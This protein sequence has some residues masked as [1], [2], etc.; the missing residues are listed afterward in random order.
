MSFEEQAARGVR[1][2][3]TAVVKGLDKRDSYFEL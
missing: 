1:G 3:M 2:V